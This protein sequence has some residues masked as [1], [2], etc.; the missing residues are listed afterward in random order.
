MSGFP[1]NQGKVKIAMTSLL[2]WLRRSRKNPRMSGFPTNQGKVK[3][4]MTSLLL[5]LRRSRK[6]PLF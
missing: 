1:T 2:L 4:A 5:W 3:I 6:N